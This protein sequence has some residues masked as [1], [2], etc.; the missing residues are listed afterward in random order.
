MFRLWVC[1]IGVSKSGRLADAPATRVAN[2]YTFL[3]L[4]AISETSSAP[5]VW[6]TS[7]ESD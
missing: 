7:F 2:W 6:L 5:I 1:A 3:A 4:V